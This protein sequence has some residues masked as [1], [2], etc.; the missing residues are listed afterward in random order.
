[1]EARMINSYKAFS[2]GFTI[3]VLSSIVGCSDSSDN[4][5]KGNPPEGIL[6]K[7]SAKQRQNFDSWKQAMIKSCDASSI[8]AAKFETR[9][10]AQGLDATLVIQK[11]AGSVVFSDSKMI[12]VISQFKMMSGSSTTEYNESESTNGQGVSLKAATKRDGENCVVFLDGQKVFETTLVE[13]AFIGS[14]WSFEKNGVRTA[15]EPQIRRIESSELSEVNTYVLRDTLSKVFAPTDESLKL[16]SHKLGLSGPET[17][18][19]LKRVN[20]SVILSSIR[21][22]NEASALWSGDSFLA[23]RTELI[24]NSFGERPR[25][26][27][28]EARMQPPSFSFGST[29]NDA[30]EVSLKFTVEVKVS[31][32]LDFFKYEAQ[33]IQFHGKFPFDRAEA[34]ACVRARASTYLNEKKP[35]DRIPTSFEDL[36]GPCE[37]LYSKVEQASFEDGLTAALLP[38]VFDGVLPSE[39]YDYNGWNKI[40]TKLALPLIMQNKNLLAE[41]DPQSQTSFLPQ[42]SRTLEALKTEL[43]HTKNL[44]KEPV[45]AMGL[46]WSFNGHAIT[47]SKTRQIVRALDNSIKPFETSTES[48]MDGLAQD[49]NR[50]PDRLNFAASLDE[51]YK[52]EALKALKLSEEVQHF[53]F[54]LDVFDRILETR[55]SLSDLQE[56]SSYL[57]KLKSSKNK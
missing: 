22:E 18:R 8:F 51:V 44:S 31:K 46:K 25:S 26:V 57:S 55:P 2:F 54:R 16:V 53:D 52:T 34:L 40:L 9:Q 37:T 38:Q 23:A 33:A 4:G 13:R 1:M 24:E 11:N 7:L 43:A 10:D 45:F 19:Y 35:M 3:F 15:N 20:S 17:E 21:F 47:S 14:E 50:H 36:F 28:L 30:D 42:I 49:P 39:R 41:L 5:N 56:W 32:N 27:L 48:L 12:A 6:S 29:R